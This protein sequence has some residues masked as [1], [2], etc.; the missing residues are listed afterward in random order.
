MP[1]ALI[2]QEYLSDFSAALVGSVWGDLIETLEKRGGLEA[3]DHDKSDVYTSFDLGHTDDTSIW[4]WQ[5]NRSVEGWGVDFIDHHSAHGKPLSYYL[6]WLELR[7][8]EMGYKYA[9]HWLPH[10]ARAKTLQTGASTIE[11]FLK[12]YPNAGI[13]PSLSVQD[14]IQAA[15]W[16]LQQRIR[17]H[18]RCA[19]G[20]GSLRQYHYEFS[21]DSKTYSSKPEHD[22]SSHDADSFRYAACVVRNTELLSRPP[23][24]PKEKVVFR[25][26]A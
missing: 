3:F 26:F 8:Q 7:A 20:I 16:L 14:G 23:E 1:D 18:P 11:Q 6:D 21:E 10:D 22:W 17:F 25:N 9:R 2:R 13:A 12:R 24:P 5:I 19:G 4:A 15:R